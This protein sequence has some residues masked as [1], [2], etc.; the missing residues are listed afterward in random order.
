MALFFGVVG[1]QDDVIVLRATQGVGLDAAR[2]VLIEKI[3]AQAVGSSKADNFQIRP[4]DPR[5]WQMQGTLAQDRLSGS[6]LVGGGDFRRDAS[7]EP[8]EEFS[9]SIPEGLHRRQCRE[10]VAEHV[11]PRAFKIGA[12][13]LQ[14]GRRAGDRY[15]L[16]FAFLAQDIEQHR[17]RWSRVGVAIEID[18]IIEVARPGTLG[19]R[20]HL[21]TEGFLI[22]VGAD[23]NAFARFIAIGVIDGK[24]YGDEY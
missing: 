12:V 4:G 9:Q 17:W 23:M 14:I 11:I 10:L 16:E 8:G 6:D 2:L 7:L 22:G 20:P 5:Y 21:F 1:V 18:D 24:A 15:A 13:R 3:D 19:Q